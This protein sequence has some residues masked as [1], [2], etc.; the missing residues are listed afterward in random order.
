MTLPVGSSSVE[1]PSSHSG[2]FRPVRGLFQLVYKLLSSSSTTLASGESLN[3]AAVP[4]HQ[5]V[6]HPSGKVDDEDADGGCTLGEKCGH[7]EIAASLSSPPPSRGRGR[8]VRFNANVEISYYLKEL[9]SHH[10]HHRR[11]K[12]S[13]FSSR[14]RRSYELELLCTPSKYRLMNHNRYSDR[15]AKA[16]V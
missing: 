15:L 10:H 4:L 13:V 8:S 6:D 2:Q 9:P 12:E 5:D 3:A 11:S 16:V 7:G 14:G 1:A